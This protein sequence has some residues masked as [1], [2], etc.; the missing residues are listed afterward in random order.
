M[1]GCVKL[2]KQS[3]SFMSHKLSQQM[4]SKMTD[5]FKEKIIKYRLD[6]E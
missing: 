4:K 5:M 1:I 3:L 2:I 6:K